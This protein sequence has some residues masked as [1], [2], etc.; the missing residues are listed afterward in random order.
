MFHLINVWASG[1]PT[2]SHLPIFG[3]AL[4][5]KFDPTGFL[6]NLHRKHKHGCLLNLAGLKVFMLFDM[7]LIQ[8]RFY[9]HKNAQQALRGFG[10]EETLGTMNLL[11]GGKLH[12]TLLRSGGVFVESQFQAILLRHINAGFAKHNS[13][14]ELYSFCRAIVLH[15]MVE[16]FFGETIL[17]KAP[18]FVDSFLE[19]Q[20]SQSK[21]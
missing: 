4:S 7:D 12:S 8:K 11:E 3:S 20:V 18:F 14:I 2:S 19:F 5:F 21:T 13:E 16:Y 17:E 6:K 10:F 1:I 9:K 15:A